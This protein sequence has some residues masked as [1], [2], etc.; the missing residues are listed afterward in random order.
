MTIGWVKLKVLAASVA[1]CLAAIAESAYASGPV[2]IP[3]NHPADIASLR[4]ATRADASAQLEFSVV[5][6]LHNQ[7]VLE[8]LLAAQQ[9]PTSSQYHHWLSAEEF[10][11]RF[12]PTA[13]QI[14]AVKHWLAEAGFVIVKVDRRSRTIA[15]EGSV[16]TAEAA[17]ATQIV[18]NGSNFGN[19]SD[20]SVPA[21]LAGLIADIRGLDNMRAVA[22]AGLH[23]MGSIRPSM[24]H[25]PTE[26]VVAMADAV[27]P[28]P[29]EQAPPLS[30]ASFDGST[31]F[32]PFDIEAFYN[33]APLI[34]AGNS[35]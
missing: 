9:D 17:F 19:T 25:S 8:K 33:E 21:E 29:S 27:D 15:V 32:G 20:P 6:G 22:P 18:S 1:V 10:N 28:P 5:L 24:V 12:G 14:D 7:A 31:A 3:G 2:K 4:A 13:A 16:A 26:L 30:G 11:Q 23:R 34:S 35:G